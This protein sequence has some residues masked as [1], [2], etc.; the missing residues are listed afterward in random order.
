MA[1][2]ANSLR[3][4]LGRN[5]SSA[6]STPNSIP[7]FDGM[8]DS[9]PEQTH[10]AASLDRAANSGLTIKDGS[11]LPLL[12]H[13]EVPGQGHA[14]QPAV[15]YQQDQPNQKFAVQEGKEH[16]NNMYGN[17]PPP[18]ELGYGG[19]N[20]QYDEWRQPM[21]SRTATPQLS[22]PPQYHA[23]MNDNLNAPQ[24]LDIVS[25]A[26]ADVQVKQEP[27]MH[28]K[29]DRDV[30]AD[31][32]NQDYHDN[33]A[34]SAKTGQN[35]GSANHTASHP[36][37]IEQE[38]GY[39][40][41]PSAKTAERAVTVDATTTPTVTTQQT[42]E[43]PIG[44]DP[45]ITHENVVTTS[46]VHSEPMH[47]QSQASFGPA[48]H[49]NSAQ[50]QYSF[51]Q[52]AQTP[53]QAILD[54]QLQRSNSK[55]SRSPSVDSV[56]AAQRHRSEE[57]ASSPGAINLSAH[58]QHFAQQWQQRQRLFSIRGLTAD[59]VHANPT[60][61]HDPMSTQDQ[62]IPQPFPANQLPSIYQPLP[63][64]E[65][66]RSST[67]YNSNPQYPAHCMAT[68]HGQSQPSWM[69]PGWS[70]DTMIPHAPPCG[71]PIAQGLPLHGLVSSQRTARVQGKEALEISDDDKPL[72]TRAQRRRS[73]TTSPM[74]ANAQCSSNSSLRLECGA[75]VPKSAVSNIKQNSVIELSNDEDDDEIGEAISWKLPDFEVTYH[76]PATPND[77]PMAK[78][79]IL[80]SK[81]NLVRSEVAL[82]EDH[83]HH[84]ME[85]FLNVFLPAQQALQTADPE[86]A[87]AVINFHTISVMV[88]EAFVQYEIGDEMGRGYG[89]HGGNID[90]QTLRPSPSSSDDEPT[91]TCSAK[92]ADVDEIFFA[93]IDRWRAG[94]MSG[95]GTLKLIRGCQE[96]C[97][98]ALDIIH[99]V[100]KHGLPQ[101]E[102]KKR[103]ERSDKGVKRGP[104]G[105]AKEAETKGKVTGKRKADA[106]EGKAPAKKGKANELTGRKKAKTEVNKTKTDVK[107]T[108]PKV[109]STPGVTVFK[110]NK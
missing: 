83:A 54:S 48:T 3:N 41:L 59:A 107:K 12:G 46:S 25:N 70:F 71:Q 32:T 62:G 4:L 35:S 82:T 16:L 60:L 80:G 69:I 79:S 29:D 47:L 15:S 101:P 43:A 84:E 5:Q 85:L 55:N 6:S 110:G 99:Y 81:K 10:R 36:S 9:Y 104:K 93:V 34:Q 103:K 30:F 17:V 56:I 42:Q 78:V 88:L 94:L 97:D 45:Q 105:D 95:K 63:I 2:F 92:D 102:P 20:V 21:P 11:A 19:G 96:F 14:C 31:F 50:Q 18:Q 67:P 68:Q 23:L 87:H 65:Q 52:Y 33:D 26:S 106:V 57:T 37:S 22:E 76:A 7:R 39:E 73:I 74:P 1:S 90:N 77:L 86:P 75:D 72:A 100:K 44:L 51:E 98:I 40:C 64:H 13:H 66:Q 49:P 8:S 91:R 108:K 53:E 61:L 58:P 38:P 89:F 24:L 28:E 27:T 109:K